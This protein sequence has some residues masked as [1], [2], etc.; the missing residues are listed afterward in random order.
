MN[1]PPIKKFIL[2]NIQS[3]PKAEIEL[4]APGTLTTV[5]G[6]SD[7]GKTAMASRSLEKLFFNT[8]PTKELI[9]RG[10]KSASITAVYDTPDNLAIAWEW[11]GPSPDKGKA[12]YTITRDNMEPIILEGSNRPGHVPEVIQELT[13]VRPVKIGNLTLNFNVSRQLDGPFLGASVSPTERYRVLGALAGTL[14]VDECVKE[15]GLEIHRSRRRE[16]ELAGDGGKQV[17]E[18]GEL[19]QKIREYDC[20]IPLKETIDTI[21]AKLV[22]IRQKQERLNKLNTLRSFIVTQDKIAKDT[23]DNIFTLEKAIEQVGQYIA[24]AEANILRHQKITA[25]HH[26]IQGINTVFSQTQLT[27]DKTKSHA[28]IYFHLK[29][30]NESDIKLTALTKL[31]QSIISENQKLTTAQQILD[32]TRGAEHAQIA[33]KDATKANHTRSIIASLNAE[34]TATR[35]TLLRYTETLVATEEVG[36]G[37]EVLDQVVAKADKVMKLAKVKLF[38]RGIGN[39]I[40]EAQQVLDT[41]AGVTRG[42][43]LL[44]QTKNKIVKYN[45]LYELEI[46]CQ[47]ELQQIDVA[48]QNIK[49]IKSEYDVAASEYRKLLLDAGICENCPVVAEVMAAA[50]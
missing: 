4:G 30:A 37:R 27:L 1:I 33:L 26:A 21:D 35:D 25:V 19:E 46:W 42:L 43:E 23:W 32:S 38:I 48:S 24:Q 29:A 8:I 10:A 22:M 31:H 47:K 40:T 34:I 6:G 41:T 50:G 16:K 49:R 17:G 7:T 28:K 14:E 3:L 44:P 45:A 5:I 11:K 9:R 15:V 36:R 2:R 20:L 18:I 39:R 12:R 13:G